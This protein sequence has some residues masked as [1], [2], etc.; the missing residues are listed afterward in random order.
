MSLFPVSPRF[1]NLGSG[2]TRLW[3]FTNVDFSGGQKCI[4][5]W[6]LDLDWDLTNKTQSTLD[7]IHD[8][9]DIDRYDYDKNDFSD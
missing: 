4:P 7:R 9:L 2:C 6:Y 3:G 8:F 5:S 1:V